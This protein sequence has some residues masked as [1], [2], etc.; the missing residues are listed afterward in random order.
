MSETTHPDV[1]LLAEVLC[2]GVTPESRVEID[3]RTNTVTITTM[4]KLDTLGEAEDV[5]DAVWTRTR[6][7]EAMRAGWP[8]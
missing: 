4:V 6:D 1:P 3:R 2:A 8:E 5:A 7:L